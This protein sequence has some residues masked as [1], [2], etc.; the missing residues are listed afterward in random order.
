MNA[1]GDGEQT[2]CRTQYIFVTEGFDNM[3]NCL[4]HNQAM[5]VDA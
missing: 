1:L 4:L 3:D 5:A 2:R